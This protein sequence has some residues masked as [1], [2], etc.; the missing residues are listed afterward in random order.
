MSNKLLLVR[1]PLTV[2]EDVI[3]NW[4]EISARVETE[5]LDYD[6]EVEMAHS[7][8]IPVYLNEV[9]LDLKS[10]ISVCTSARVGQ[11][12]I[13]FIVDKIDYFCYSTVLGP[14]I[15]RSDMKRYDIEEE[16]LNDKLV[17]I[18]YCY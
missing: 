18:P 13:S 17:P 4:D 2:A 6:L 15:I 10:G 16:L 9:N 12:F 3:S 11:S 8:A 7:G 5:R 1:I 14:Y